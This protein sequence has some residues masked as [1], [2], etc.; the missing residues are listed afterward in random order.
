MTAC[1]VCG[2]RD[3]QCVRFTVVGDPVAKERPRLGKGRTYTPKRTQDAEA[4][5][6]AAL[7]TQVG[8]CDPFTEP[9]RLDLVFYC[10]TRHRKDA[11]NLAKLVSDAANKIIFLD[12]V[13]VEYIAVRVIRGAGRG[14]GRTLV[15]VGPLGTVQTAWAE[16]A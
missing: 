7:A 10:E 15:H 11:D 8:P 4:A 14:H 9:V 1:P 12:D 5:V 3:E 16:T 13:L 2:D 6:R